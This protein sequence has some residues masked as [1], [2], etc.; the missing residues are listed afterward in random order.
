MA[1]WA[2]ARAPKVKPRSMP[3]TTARKGAAGRAGAAGGSR[4]PARRPC[5]CAGTGRRP[6]SPP[7]GPAPSPASRQFP[8]Q[9]GLADHQ[10]RGAF[11]QPLAQPAAGDVA[12][13]EHPVG[14]GRQAGGGQ[15]FGDG[16]PVGGGIV[17]D[18]AE[19]EAALDDVGESLGGVGKDRSRPARRRRRG[20]RRPG[21]PGRRPAAGPAPAAPAPLARRGAARRPER[22]RLLTPAS[23][24]ASTCPCR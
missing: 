9:P 24:R 6:E 18:I 23:V 14:A 12:G 22:L 8:Q 17:A 5:A 11:R 1:A 10:H 19:V 16:L 2:W 7:R 3:T 21:A 20:R 13:G 4:R 15:P